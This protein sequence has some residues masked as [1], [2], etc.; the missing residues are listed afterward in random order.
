MVLENR[1]LKFEANTCAKSLGN[2]GSGMWRVA[3]IIWELLDSGGWYHGD[4][5]PYCTVR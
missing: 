3:G 1:E 5:D 4:T 2:P